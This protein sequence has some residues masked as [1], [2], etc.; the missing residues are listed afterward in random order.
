MQVLSSG[1]RAAITGVSFNIDFSNFKIKNNGVKVPRYFRPCYPENVARLMSL[2]LPDTLA[3]NRRSLLI[4]TPDAPAWDALGLVLRDKNLQVE[5]LPPELDPVLKRSAETIPR[6]ILLDT[7]PDQQV[8]LC[9]ALRAAM[10]PASPAIFAVVDSPAAALS[11]LQAGAIDYLLTP[12]DPGVAAP[13]I[14]LRLLTDE[15]GSADTLADVRRVV[16]DLKNPLGILTGYTEHLLEDLEAVKQAELA[17]VLHRM[18][19]IEA[20]MLAQ[21]NSLLSER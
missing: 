19:R 13:R 21:L 11:I 15:Q 3:A 20:K 1:F 7:D 6:S 5:V 9:R 12:V 18:R 10:A 2:S 14:L 16:H 17:M 4:L 8:A